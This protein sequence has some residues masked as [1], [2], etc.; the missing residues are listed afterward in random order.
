LAD[1]QRRLDRW[2]RRDY[3]LA[4]LTDGNPTES[5]GIDTIQGISSLAWAALAP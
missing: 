4:V 3:L 2:A 5:Y 1:Q